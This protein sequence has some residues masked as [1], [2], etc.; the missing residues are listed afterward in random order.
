MKVSGT[1][2]AEWPVVE[3]QGQIIWM[4]GAD[5]AAVPGIVVSAEEE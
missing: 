1:Q 3:W 5:L 2:R 4:K